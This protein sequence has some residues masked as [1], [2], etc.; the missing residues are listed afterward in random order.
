LP[1]TFNEVFESS[2][3]AIGGIKFKKK[4]YAGSSVYGTIGIEQDISHNVSTLSPS[5]VSGITTVD[6]TKNHNATRAVLAVGYDLKLTHNAILRLKF[7]YQELPYQD[8]T[9]ENTYVSYNLL[10]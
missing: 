10:F 9:E 1:L 4:T 8:M 3:V 2:W 5:G 7:Q 6:L